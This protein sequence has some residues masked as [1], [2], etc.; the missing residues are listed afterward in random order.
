MRLRLVPALPHRDQAGVTP[1]EIVAVRDWRSSDCSARRAGGARGCRRYVRAG[2]DLRRRVGGMRAGA[3]EPAVLVEMVVAI[4]NWTM[5][6]QLLRSL[7][8]DRSRRH[9]V[10]AGRQGAG[11]SMNI[12]LTAGQRAWQQKA[13]EFAQDE[14]S[15]FRSGRTRSPTRERRSTGTS[16]ARARSSASAP[17]SCRG[18]AAATA[19][20]PSRRSSS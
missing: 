4:G 20:T 10:A 2:K 5:F 18:T 6:A 1:E 8:A 16:S 11:D 3:E 7:E 9:A 13:R 19:S 14:L 15:P 17:P 12:S